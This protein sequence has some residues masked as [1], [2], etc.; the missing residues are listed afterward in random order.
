MVTK[1]K[2]TTKATKKSRVKVG[3]LKVNKETVKDLTGD[4]SKKVKG[5]VGA[6]KPCAPSLVTTCPGALC[7]Y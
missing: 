1:K 5:G 6:R 4:E 2:T 7:E 3:K